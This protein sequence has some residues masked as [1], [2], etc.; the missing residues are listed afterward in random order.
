MGKWIGRILFLI[1][2]LTGIW[3][4]YKFLRYIWRGV[5]KRPLLSL[6]ITA[7]AV[8]F[9]IGVGFYFLNTYDLSQPKQTV[10]VEYS[11]YYID[12]GLLTRT[13]YMRYYAVPTSLVEPGSVYR[14]VADNGAVSFDDKVYWTDL[15]YNIVKAKLVKHKVSQD[16]YSALHLAPLDVSVYEVVSERNALWLMI[17]AVYAGIIGLA[18]SG[19][20]KDY[21]VQKTACVVSGLSDEEKAKRCFE[22]K[23]IKIVNGILRCGIDKCIYPD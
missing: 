14:I 8:S 10:S 11:K 5:K 12:D 17:P 9:F 1:T 22:C 19:R 13:P 4:V 16:E 18:M 21:S 2:I 3:L 7:G 23:H 6:V 15:E 20:G